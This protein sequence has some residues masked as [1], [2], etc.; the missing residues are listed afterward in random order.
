M[1]VLRIEKF[2]KGEFDLS[3]KIII[4]NG[5][6]RV[7]GNTS[8]LVNEFTRGAEE[9]GCEV[10]IFQLDKMNI[11]GCKG[12]FGGG[13][14]I[15]SPCVQKDDMDKIYPV[16]READI[17][18]L[19]T[20]LYYWNFS[21]QLRTTFDRLF[22]VAECDPNYRNP[23]KESV[24]LMAAE[25]YGFD[26]ALQYYQNLMKHLGWTELGHV[27]AGGVMKVGDIKDH[28]ELNQAYELGKKVDGNSL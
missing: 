26:D 15:E 21:G 12:C 13:K 20:P 1:I 8:A 28:K 24:L 23:K 4:L 6:P 19:A 16:Y 5:S 22:A 25:G 14:N 18:V 11:H 7:K 3:K 27:L 2:V 9:V 10:K 17:V